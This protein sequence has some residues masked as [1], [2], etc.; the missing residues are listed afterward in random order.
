MIRPEMDPLPIPVAGP[1][2]VVSLSDADKVNGAWGHRLCLE[3]P[4][5]PGETRTRIKVNVAN[6]VGSDWS[7]TIS[8]EQGIPAICSAMYG[9]S[10]VPVSCKEAADR[11]VGS[12]KKS[13][14]QEVIR[15]K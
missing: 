11:G 1:V 15:K 8:V 13:Y 7:K 4:F 5:G 2:P 12:L 9:G 3:R 6:K 10:L 14:A